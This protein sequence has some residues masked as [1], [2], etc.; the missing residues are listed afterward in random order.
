MYMIENES[1]YQTKTTRKN[2][3]PKRGATQTFL[4]DRTASP[5]C[6]WDTHYTHTQSVHG[7]TPPTAYNNNTSNNSVCVR[8]EVRIK[9]GCRNGWPLESGHLPLTRF[10]MVAL[11]DITRSGSAKRPNDY[12]YA[13]FAGTPP[14]AGRLHS[15][16]HSANGIIYRS[17]RNAH[18]VICALHVRAQTGK[19]FRF[20]IQIDIV[21]IV[22]DPHVMPRRH[23]DLRRRRENPG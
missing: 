3:K 13:Y 10:A 15:T 8:H 19:R 5:L 12:A 14:R 1:R 7:Y 16:R 6:E 22:Y 17:L 11:R 2:P 20:E 4:S 23:D 21:I 9:N 18:Y